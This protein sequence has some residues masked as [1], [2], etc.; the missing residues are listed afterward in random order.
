MSPK[1]S[2]IIPVFN[3]EEYVGECLDSVISQTIGDIE[4]IVVNDGSTDNSIQIIREYEKSDYRIVVIDKENE[5]AGPSRNKGIQVA[6]GE[7]LAFL[8]ADDFY[9]SN[10]VLEE[11]YNAACSENVKIAG[12]KRVRLMENGEFKYDPDVIS[13]YGEKISASGKMNYTEF[14][15]DY[16]YQHY[17]YDRTMIIDN[18]ITFPD[19]RRFQDPPFFVKAMIASSSFY[20]VDSYTYCYRR[21][22]QEK[23]SE[24]KWTMP[25]AIDMIKGMTENLELSRKNSLAKLHYITANRIN[26]EGSYVAIRNFD[27]KEID[28]LLYLLIKANQTVDVKWLNQNG[29]NITDPFVLSVFKYAV[30]TTNKYEKLRNKK[31]LKPLKRIVRK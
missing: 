28:E 22:F 30:D 14:Q 24:M 17:I 26:H 5:G 15:Y 10:N 6:K 11:L 19:Y 1:V 25:K 16:G 29:Y 23:Y 31:I 7:F 21:T 8:D 4:I 18:A 27:N 12:G 20:F 13:V 2:V 3:A 9:P